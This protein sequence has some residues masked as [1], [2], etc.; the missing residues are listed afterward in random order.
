MQEYNNDFFSLMYPSNWEY[1]FI[2]TYNNVV[3]IVKG[4]SGK[5]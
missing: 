1:E 3:G 5:C 4:I 2:V